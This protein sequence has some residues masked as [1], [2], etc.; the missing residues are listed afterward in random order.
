MKDKQVLV[1]SAQL[2][3]IA[4]ICRLCGQLGYPVEESG[5]ASRLKTILADVEQAVFVAVNQNGGVIGWVHVLQVLYLETEPFAEIG[6][7]VVE[8]TFRGQGTGKML[9]QAAEEWAIKNTLLDIRLRSNSIRE[10]AHVF[11]KAIGYQHVKTQF[12]FHK[13]ITG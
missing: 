6:G 2:Q 4:D 12:T 10:N 11:Y 8:E 3:D 5:V 7:L 1:R 13:R 9:M